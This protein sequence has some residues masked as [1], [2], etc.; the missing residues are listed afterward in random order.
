M[1][2]AVDKKNGS[3]IKIKYC[4]PDTRYLLV[5]RNTLFSTANDFFFE[6]QVAYLLVDML[7]TPRR[8]SIFRP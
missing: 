4:Y 7:L 3:L 1:R 5:A 8:L 2:T 6:A